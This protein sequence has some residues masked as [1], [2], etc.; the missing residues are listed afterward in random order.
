[1]YIS[2]DTQ[3]NTKW[4]SHHQIILV[5]GESQ[6]L[7]GGENKYQ[8][9]LPGGFGLLCGTQTPV[10]LLVFILRASTSLSAFSLTD[11]S[12]PP[13]VTCHSQPHRQ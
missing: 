7:G 10:F 4:T 6:N 13:K 12:L 2:E 8:L 11:S 9:Q 3:A 5:Q 1:M